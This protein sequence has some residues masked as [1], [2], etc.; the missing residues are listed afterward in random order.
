MTGE[1]CKMKLVLIILALGFTLAGHAQSLSAESSKEPPK[2]KI[3]ELAARGSGLANEFC[4]RSDW[5]KVENFGEDTIH[6]SDHRIFLSDDVNRLKKFRLT[7]M[8]VAPNS[9]LII[10][11]DDIGIT[12]DQIH[13]NFKL[14]AQGETISLAIK[15]GLRTEIID[16]VYYEELGDEAQETLLRS[17]SNLLV[18]RDEH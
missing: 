1:F 13:T 4:M 18:Y 6:L 16:Q 11:C 12:R 10:W 7:K 2:L 5:L 9:T 15:R 3:V 8:S 17:E 14:S